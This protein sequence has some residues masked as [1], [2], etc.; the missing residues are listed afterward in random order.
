[1][2]GEIRWYEFLG[3]C[4][5]FPAAFIG[6]LWLV[7]RITGSDPLV[8]EIWRLR[9]KNSVLQERIKQLEDERKTN[10]E[11]VDDRR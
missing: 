11:T 1:M 10:K 4:V 8:E 7:H 5:F 6:S 9:G 2:N 3:L